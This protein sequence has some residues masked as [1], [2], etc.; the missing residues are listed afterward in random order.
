ML[1]ERD[2]KLSTM[3]A[4]RIAFLL[5]NGHLPPA[6]LL[7]RH[8]CGERA[9]CNPAHLAAGTNKENSRDMVRHGRA[10]RASRSYGAHPRRLIPDATV[11]VIKLA[12]EA[13]VA[14]N[15]IAVN[16]GVPTR[17]INDIA[18][19]QTYND[20]ALFEEARPK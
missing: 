4:H 3:K 14:Q 7:V 5:G 17:L 8:L 6:P 13:G 2:G 20:I 16:I 9:C 19:G 12:L 1:W 10:G 15:R 11:R 18:R